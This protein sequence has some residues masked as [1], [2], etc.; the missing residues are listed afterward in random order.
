MATWCPSL[1]LPQVR[2]DHP[3]REV[4]G[5]SIGIRGPGRQRGRTRK[6][7]AGP[8]GGA[9]TVSDI[10]FRGPRI[11]QGSALVKRQASALSSLLRNR[12]L[13]YFTGLTVDER[14]AKGL[15]ALT[16]R[17]QDAFAFLGIVPVGAG[18]AVDEVAFEGAI[19]QDRDL[20]GRGADGLCLA[21]PDGEAPIERAE[22]GLGPPGR[23]SAW[24]SP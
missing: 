20:A 22:R 1:P 3:I 9:K 18:V 10:R 5:P 24:P 11:W 16:E 19:D 17:P 7:G 2:G 23:R 14:K 12:A 6:V 21:D 8:C 4:V 13:E 15:G